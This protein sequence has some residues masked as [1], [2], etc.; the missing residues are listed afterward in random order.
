M[1]NLHFLTWFA[2]YCFDIVHVQFEGRFDCLVLDGFIDLDYAV[3]RVEFDLIFGFI[4]WI[5][6]GFN[7]S[8][9]T[10]P[11]VYPGFNSNAR[12]VVS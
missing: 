5:P 8:V 9:E 2:L 1:V 7:F 11:I 6:V 10:F 3:G 4:N 12:L